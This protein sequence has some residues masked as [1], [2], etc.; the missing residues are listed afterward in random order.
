MEQIAADPDAT[1]RIERYT[2]RKNCSRKLESKLGLGTGLAVKIVWKFTLTLTLAGVL[3][4]STYKTVPQGNAGTDPVDVLIVLGMPAKLDGSPS[5][6][7]IWRVTEAAHEFERGKGQ[8]ILVS[9]GAAANRFVEAD[10]M[11]RVARQLG[12]PSEALVEERSSLTTLENIRNSEDIL[13][14]HHWNRV[15]VIS[16]SDHLPRAAVLLSRTTLQ[17]RVHDAPTPGRGRINRAMAYTKEAVATTILRWFGN[18][19]EPFI[20]AVAHGVRNLSRDLKSSDF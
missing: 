16:S 10:A 19:A 4:L 7:E 17:W 18:R 8:Y 2:A 5:Q 6:A 12:V 1:S 15:E 20:H 3:V 9:G 14:D 13:M 11:A